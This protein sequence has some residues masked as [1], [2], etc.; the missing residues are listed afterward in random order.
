MPVLFCS[1]AMWQDR[2]DVRRSLAARGV[3]LP[4]ARLARPAHAPVTCD[5]T[6]P[7]NQNQ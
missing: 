6:L 2:M 1:L 7:T 5:D 4:L 3:I